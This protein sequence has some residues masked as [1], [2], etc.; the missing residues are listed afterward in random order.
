MRPRYFQSRHIRFLTY[1]HVRRVEDIKMLFSHFF[2]CCINF[3]RKLPRIERFIAQLP[4]SLPET[5]QLSCLYA[6]PL[7]IILTYLSLKLKQY[8]LF[9]VCTCYLASFKSSS[10]M[11]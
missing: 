3:I 1:I 11:V 9:M 5:P 8:T 7:P 2:I 6:T 10:G 4:R